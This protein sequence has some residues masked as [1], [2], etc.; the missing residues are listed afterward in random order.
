VAYLLVPFLNN[1]DT[2]YFYFASCGNGDIFDQ[3]VLAQVL[4]S[5]IPCSEFMYKLIPFI[6]LLGSTLIIWKTS[7]LLYKKHA[8][9]APIALFLTPAWVLM[10]S[11]F[12]NDTFA[13]FTLVVALYFLIKSKVVEDKKQYW[14]NIA[15]TIF[16]LIISGLI[17]TGSFYF[18]F[19]LAGTSIPILLFASIS[20]L[21][22]IV[23]PA[24]IVDNL[25]SFLVFTDVTENAPIL[26]FLILFWLTFTLVKLHPQLKLPT[27]TFIVIALF[28]VKLGW[29]AIPLLALNFP[30]L[31]AYIEQKKG[32]ELRK[33]F[34]NFFIMGAII[35]TIVSAS[36]IVVHTFPSYEM[37]EGAKDTVELSQ[38]KGQPI[39][40]DWH[41]GY[42]IKYFGGEPSN[43]GQP[44]GF[45]YHK[46]TVV[47]T[48]KTKEE[49]Y[50]CVEVKSYYE[51]IDNNFMRLWQ[52]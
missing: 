1:P 47:L 50:R 13:Y 11:K 39:F 27:I 51:T 6:L 26:G 3:P 25:L 17:W 49:M 2:Y 10:F 16:F 4:F 14:L 7:E 24:L 33:K 31:V 19:G 37:M 35:T 12:E 45:E 22:G 18:L 38:E 21:S 20:I 34:V 9:I 15:A 5:V 32:I 29:F 48:I 30:N 41:M 36:V 44:S 42:F 43:I 46:D 8:F 28:N 40:N 23:N 52:C